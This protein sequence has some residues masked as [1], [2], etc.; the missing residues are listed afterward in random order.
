MD[1]TEDSETRYFIDIDLKTQKVV[2]WGL[3]QRETLVSQEMAEPHHHRVFISRGQYHKL[4]NKAQK[5][6]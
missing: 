1:R 3:G 6:G 2:Q 5:L 4:V